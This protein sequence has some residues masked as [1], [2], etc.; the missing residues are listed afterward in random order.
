[1][2][3]RELIEWKVVTD[4]PDASDEPTALVEETIS[5]EQQ[6]AMDARDRD[7]STPA[8]Q[9]WYDAF[10]RNK[11][12]NDITDFEDL[13]DHKKW[14]YASEEGIAVRNFDRDEQLERDLA[15]IQAEQD[16]AD[17]RIAARNRWEKMQADREAELAEL[18]EKFS[19]LQLQLD[20]AIAD[21]D[22]DKQSAIEE[23]GELVAW[24]DVSG[25][26]GVRVRHAG[27]EGSSLAR[28]EQVR[29]DSASRRD[30]VPLG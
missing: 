12:P 26:P 20:Q 17:A 23:E 6:V 7:P 4:S 16:A 2:F 14:F 1:M 9:T 29:R 22:K 24:F 15:A 28:C 3:D 10:E 25:G 21:G 18:D 11:D 27:D 30:L 5:K 19:S 8:G 13:S